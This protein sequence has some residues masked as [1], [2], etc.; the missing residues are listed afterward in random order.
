MANERHSTATGRPAVDVMVGDD[1]LG[2]A[3]SQIR[4][5]ARILTLA[6]IG[7]LHSPHDLGHSS[8]GRERRPI[9][10]NWLYDLE[11]LGFDLVHQI[12]AVDEALNRRAGS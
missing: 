2:D 12:E 10:D 11:A 7:Y 3:V 8:Q 4:H 5:S 1:H 6:I 9:A